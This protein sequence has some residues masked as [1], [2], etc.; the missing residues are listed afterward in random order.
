MSQTEKKDYSSTLNLPQTE[1]PM[2]GN[3]PEREPYFLKRMQENKI[4]EKALE[5]NKK[6]G[7]KFILHDGPP[8]ANGNIHMGHALNKVL[9]DIVIRY[10][11][12]TGHYSPYVPGWDT[13]GLPIEKKVQIEKKITKDDVGAAKFRD[14]CKEY[15]LNAVK[16]QAEQFKRLGGLGDYDKVRYLTLNPEFE[17]SQIQVFWDMYKKGY[18]YRDLKPVY[19]CSDCETALAEAEIEYADHETTSIYVKFRVKDDKGKLAK[20]GDLQDT[21]I[22]IWTTTPWTLPAN[23]AITVNKDYTYAIVEVK[24]KDKTNR[25]LMAKDLVEQVMSQAFDSNFKIVGEIKGEELE[26]ILCYQPLDLNRTSRVILGSDKDLIVTLDAGTGCVHTAPGHGHEDYLAC[27]RYGD[28]EITVPV[29][30]K[31]NM[32][33]EAGAEFEG[34]SYNDA[35]KKILEYLE[36][37]GFLFAKK[38]LNHSYPHCWRCKKPVIYRAAIQWFAS[39]DGFRDQVLEEIKNI[40]WIPGWGTERMTNMIKDRTDWCISR[41]RVWGVPIP[42]FYCKECGKELINEETIETIKKK[43]EISGSSIWY[44]LTPEQLLKGYAKCD[45][46]CTELEKETDIMD[47]WFD[48]GTTYSSVL[49]DKKYGIESDQADMYLE[50]NDQYRGWFQSSM[51]TSVAS[52]GKAPYKEVLTHGWV[53]D[54]EGRKMSKSLGNGVDPLD[55]VKEYGADILRLWSVSSD[56]HSD[57]RISKDILAQVSEVYK[58]I[59]NT[60][61]FLLGNLSDFNPIFN[62]VEYSKRDELDRYMMYKTNRL[63]QYL[64]TQYENYDF[65]LVYSELHRFCTVELSNKYLD[66]IKD[67]LYVLKADHPLRRSSQSTMYEVLQILV[68]LMAPILSFT[69]DEIWSYMRHTNEENPLSVL[70]AEIPVENIE[71]NDEALIE[72]WDKI[73]EIKENLAKDIEQARANKTIGNA[74]DARVV[75]S[76][77]D[78]D[79]EF[80]KAN[81]EAIKLVLIVSQFDVEESKEYKVFVD[82]A[83]GDKC[84]RCWTYS[85]EVGRDSENRHLCKKCIENI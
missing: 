84:E 56:Y 75:V 29:D 43:I 34:L 42:I 35:N 27:K 69:A 65:H 23:Q 80:M 77:S 38:K 41:Q 81:K 54:G 70:F 4:Y 63:T 13:H 72:K 76:T 17:A 16:N 62:L 11:T 36:K 45:C 18:I 28:I 47:V 37:T 15:A 8:Y 26:N 53:V 78:G 52:R 30:K 57:M 59:R 50:G 5:K 83:Y 64:N 10:K 73:F 2:R 32:T 82:K 22:V 25:Y 60:M 33:K 7:K 44:E 58:K 49:S 24:E 55:I 48:S 9:K 19:W 67:R 14:I 61:R 79:L 3:L 51:L 71:Y 40:R 85:T 12:M 1:F 74:L 68:K 46:G 31:G 66:V 20:Y 21:Y 39:I 6:S